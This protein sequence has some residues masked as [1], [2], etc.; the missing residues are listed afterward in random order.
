MTR[1]ARRRPGALS[2]VLIGTSIGGS[3]AIS[4][5]MD[6]LLLRYSPA[7]PAE[8][9][10]GAVLFNATCVL[11]SLVGG[12]IEWQRPHT[13]GRLLMLTGPLYAF[14][15]AGWTTAGTLESIVDPQIYRV[16][17]WGGAL[18]SYP[19]VAL[20]VGWVPL[21]F[22]TGTLPGP[23]WRVPVGALVILSGIGLAAWAVRPSWTM[24]GNAQV[25]PIGIDG[26]PA[27][28]QP[29]VD[30][31]PF[32]LIALIALAVAALITRYWRG[33]RIERLQIRWF[34][35]AVAVCAAGFGGV[36]VEM[37]VRTDDG[38]LVSALVAYAGI[39]A[40]PIAIGIAV[41]R[42]RL[43]ELDRLISRTLSYAVVTGILAVV[44]VGVI[45]LLQALLT[46]VT[47]GQT[48]A[49]AASTLA[50]LT[51]FQPVLRRV[52]HTLDRRFD[53]ARYDAEQTVLAFSDRLRSETDMEAV[54]TELA[55]TAGSTVSP[56]RLTIWLRPRDAGG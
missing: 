50:V 20:I 22:P 3:A 36:L 1:L 51:L 55:R 7:A 8:I 40:M 6:A 9:L 26:W 10:V 37:A 14:L 21:L 48:I 29:L 39:L 53:R 28:L 2:I 16:V 49:V 13:I 15:A 27:F 4:L 34:G 52:R 46:P 30:A 17:N 43:Y 12:I 11:Q 23:R 47:G 56:S 45:L 24:N 25:S 41:T 42:Y 54:T 19:G 31:I 33:D 44:F 18:L 38:L 32:E 35:A 5:A